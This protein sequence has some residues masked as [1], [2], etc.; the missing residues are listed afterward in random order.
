MLNERAF[1]YNRTNMQL[2]FFVLLYFNKSRAYNERANT[3]A[4]AKHSNTVELQCNASF[5]WRWLVPIHVKHDRRRNMFANNELRG[6]NRSYSVLLS[7]VA[8]AP[9]TRRVIIA[10]LAVRR[11]EFMYSTNHAVK[12]TSVAFLLFHYLWSFVSGRTERDAA[13]ADKEFCCSIALGWSY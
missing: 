6:I 8:A 9:T 12:T 3:K 11:S 10:A 4:K 7:C 1:E 2:S 13:A 5:A